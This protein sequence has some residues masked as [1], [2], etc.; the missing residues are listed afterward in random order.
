MQLNE[1]CTWTATPVPPAPP[2]PAAARSFV[3]DFT[4]GRIVFDTSGEAWNHSLNPVAPLPTCK[5]EGCISGYDK[6]KRC[7]CDVDCGERGDCCRDYEEVCLPPTPESPCSGGARS[8]NLPLSECLAMQQLYDATDGAHWHNCGANFR[9]DPCG[10]D[11]GVPYAACGGDGGGVCCKTKAGLPAAGQTHVTQIYLGASG[12][13]GSLPTD[14]RALTHLKWLQLSCNHI[15]GPVPPAMLNWASFDSGRNDRCE[16]DASHADCALNNPP[17]P[18]NNFSCPIPD[19][20][21]AHCMATCVY[22]PAP[23]PSKC[24]SVGGRWAWTQ[25]SGEQS[26]FDIAQVQGQCNITVSG[27]CD[28][29]GPGPPGTPPGWKGPSPGTIGMKNISWVV[30]PAAPLV[31]GEVGTNGKL[32]QIQWVGGAKNL[33]VWV[34]CQTLPPKTCDTAVL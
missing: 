23:T 9:T 28:G 20:A 5:L 25:D 29:C 18:N 7:N 34:D 33:G 16:L 6:G 17:L 10:C 32:R 26:F 19:G 12:L 21:A 24:I 1:T 30:R 15:T 27:G 22:K 8:A 3:F 14:L 4:T 2:V 31:V 13:A 11:M